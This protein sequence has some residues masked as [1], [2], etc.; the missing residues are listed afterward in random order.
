MSKEND[1]IKTSEKHESSTNS[2]ELEQVE[3]LKSYEQFNLD[4]SKENKKDNK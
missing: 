1:E 4:E 2:P 3:V